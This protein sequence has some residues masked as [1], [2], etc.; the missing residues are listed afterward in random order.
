MDNNYYDDE[1]KAFILITEKPV[2]ENIESF[3]YY[4]FEV[5]IIIYMACTIS[6]A[7]ISYTRYYFGEKNE[8]MQK[9]ISFNEEIIYMP[10]KFLFLRSVNNSVEF[11]FVT[12]PKCL[13]RSY[14]TLNLRVFS[15]FLNL[16]ISKNA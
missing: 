9:L 4:L 13:V 6:V 14:D 10:E 1:L 5:T 8:E 7:V 15:D 12:S 3:Q 11:N 16:S 2:I